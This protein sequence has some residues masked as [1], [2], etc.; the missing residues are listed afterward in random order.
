[1]YKIL[2]VIGARPQ[3]IKSAAISHAIRQL[4]NNTLQEDIL[5][6]GQH[7]APAMSAN[8]ID[9]LEL[10]QPLYNLNVG[11]ATHGVQTAEMLKGIE[12]VLLENSYDGVLVYGDTNSTLAGALAA[13]KLNV[14]VF[15][16]EAGLRSLRKDM[17]EEIN[18][19]LTDHVSNILFTP[20]LQ[21]VYNL[22]SEGI[23]DKQIVNCGDVMLDN[24]LRYSHRLSKRPLIDGCY[25]LAT[26]H[27][28]FNTDNATRLQTIFNALESIALDHECTI[29]LPLHPRTKARLSEMPGLTLSHRIKIIEP[30]GYI[31]TLNLIKYSKIVLTDS[32]GLQKEAYFLQRPCVILRQET[33]WKEIVE[34]GAAALTEPC[35]ESILNNTA[36]LWNKQV[37][38]TRLFGDGTAAQRCIATIMAYFRHCNER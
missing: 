18:R 37:E 3:F 16:I 10:T 31:D 9:E 20:T 35:V 6:T 2:T 28:N 19:I 17:P 25:A 15:H 34:E 23:S 36:A 38:S 14:P 8:Y 22:Q 26:I 12:R 24:V 7:Y 21:A 27:R 29:I 5:N 4:P 1:M 30:T 33:E 32:G 11:S 13:S